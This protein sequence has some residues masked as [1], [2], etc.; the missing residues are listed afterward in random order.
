MK[1]VLFSLFISSVLLL[2]GCQENSMTNPVSPS[3]NKNDLTNVTTLQGIIPIDQKITNTVPGNAD[4]ILNGKI[5]YTESIVQHLGPQVISTLA[6]GFDVMTNISIDAILKGI[7]VS[8]VE[9]NG[10]RILSKSSDQV[11]VR[12]D[13][14]SVLIKSYPVLGRT[15]KLVFTFVVTVKGIRLDRVILDSPM[16]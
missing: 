11:F 2:V 4:F 14:S 3:L 9:Q 5:N 7:R 16:M 13:G 8:N 1:K 10:W 6:P 12:A 15:D